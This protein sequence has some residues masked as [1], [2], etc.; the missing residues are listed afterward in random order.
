MIKYTESKLKIKTIKNDDRMFYIK[1]ALTMTPRAG[2]EVS[3]QCPYEYRLVL[4]ECIDRG[5]IKPVAYMRDDEYI[6]ESLK[7]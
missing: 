3:K 7:G 2:F 4:T 5:W 6:W 1:G